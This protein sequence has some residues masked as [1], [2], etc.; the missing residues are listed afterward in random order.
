MCMLVIPHQE[1][2]VA[3]SRNS[4]PSSRG[5]PSASLLDRGFKRVGRGPNV[6]YKSIAVSPSTSTAFLSQ[7]PALLAIVALSRRTS[8]ASAALDY[9]GRNFPSAASEGFLCCAG[10][11]FVA[12]HTLV[13][14]WVSS[15]LLIWKSDPGL[16]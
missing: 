16:S 7:L 8:S 6:V 2:G 13:Q 5:R 10:L 15:F 11:R 4:P 14:S 9:P 1:T 3:Y 12:P